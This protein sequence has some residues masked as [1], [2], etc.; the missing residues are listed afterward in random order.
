MKDPNPLIS[1]FFLD[2]RA[3]TT[4]SLKI[5]TTSFKSEILWF[6]FLFRLLIRLSRQLLFFFFFF[7]IAFS[8]I[9]LSVSDLVAPS[10]NF[11]INDFSSSI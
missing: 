6:G 9:P 1:I 11:A 10:P 4:H 2:L 5:S 7:P 3:K 8:N